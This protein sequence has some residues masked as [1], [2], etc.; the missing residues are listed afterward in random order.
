MR[1]RASRLRPVAQACALAACCAG[2]SAAT[3]TGLVAPFMFC[4]G[5]PLASVACPIGALQH[6]AALRRFP[7]LLLGM[8]GLAFLLLGRAACGW[9]CPF[10]ALQDLLARLL[11]RKKA[12]TRETGLDAGLRPVKWLVLAGTL[13]SAYLIGGTT[14]CWFCPIGTLFAAIPYALLMPGARLSLFFYVHLATL[15][16]VLIWASLVPRAWC[17]YLCPLGALAGQANHVSLLTIELDERAC[18]KCMACLRAC[19]MGLADLASIS[20]PECVLCGRC[21]EACPEGAPRLAVRR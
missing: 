17:R 4:H 7:F 9:L 13:L 1:V 8:L 16:G 12:M 21:V 6:F 18:K 3:Q 15:A 20:G 10:G 14:F 2:F 11:A 5:C 19:P